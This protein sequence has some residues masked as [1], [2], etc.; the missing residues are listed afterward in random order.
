[1]RLVLGQ[2][3]AQVV[4]RCPP[5]TGRG[6]GP[7]RRSRRTSCRSGLSRSS[8][9]VSTRKVKPPP[10]LRCTLRVNMHH[11]VTLAG[12]LGVPEDAELSRT[13]P[14]GSRTASTARLTPRNWWLRARILRVSPVDSSNRMKFSTRSRKLRLVADALQQ[15][16]H[17]DRAWLVLGQPLPFVEMAPTAGDRSNPRLLAVAEHHHRVVVEQVRDGVAVVRVVL[18]V[19]GLQV[20]V[21]VLALHEQ[22]RQAVDEAD[23]VRTPPVQG[24]RAPTARARRGSGCSPGSSKSRTRSRR[25]TSRLPLSSRNVTC[26]PSRTQAVLLP[27]GGNDG[28]ATPLVAVMRRTP[29]SYAAL[30]QARIQRRRASSR[31]GR[32]QHHLAVPTSGRAGCPA[33][34]PPGCTRTT[35]SQ[36]SSCSR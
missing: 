33:Q 15:R 8:R 28:L 34:S 17:V 26:T 29:S 13:S 16:L 3:L 27:V 25:C 19:G 1:M 11:R 12:A 24:G 10:S 7:P 23:D 30:R 31:S 2:Q 32:V 14:A 20:A 9:S 35:D 22:Q 6:R 36:P 18:L 5:G 21:D 4:R